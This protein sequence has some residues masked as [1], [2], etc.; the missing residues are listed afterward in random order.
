MDGNKKGKLFSA[1]V[2]NDRLKFNL[3]K[4]DLSHL[5]IYLNSTLSL[6]LKTVIL[7]TACIVSWR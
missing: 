3:L 7:V 5:K 4:I 1:F 6:V 2:A